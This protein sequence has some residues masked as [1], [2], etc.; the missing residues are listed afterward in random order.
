MLLLSTLELL[1][2]PPLSSLELEALLLS[3]LELLLPPPLSSFELEV[4]LL[5]TLELLLPPLSSLELVELLLSTLE[6]PPLSSFELDALLLS[7]LEFRPLLLSSLTLASLVFAL[8]IASLELSATAGVAV[9]TSCG[10]GVSTRETV[11]EPSGLT[12]PS[13]LIRSPTWKGPSRTIEF[14]DRDRRAADNP[15]V[16]GNTIDDPDE[17]HRHRVHF[18]ASARRDRG[19]CRWRGCSAAGAQEQGG[20]G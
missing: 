1:L 7:T 10:V 16:S 9:R 4:L 14:S 20:D 13:T 17:C 3:T 6:L 5:S 11:K 15:L 2:P 19:G 8:L 12:K 18:A